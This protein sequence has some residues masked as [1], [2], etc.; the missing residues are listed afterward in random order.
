MSTRSLL[1]FSG[2]LLSVACPVWAQEQVALTEQP[3]REVRYAGTKTPNAAKL[4]GAES[5]ATVP[6]EERRARINSLQKRRNALKRYLSTV[7]SSSKDYQATEAAIYQLDVELKALTA[8]APAVPSSES[9]GLYSALPPLPQGNAAGA[10]AQSPPCPKVTSDV[11]GFDFNALTQNEICKVIQ[12][13]ATQKTKNGQTETQAIS[14]KSTSLV[15][16]PDSPD[17]GAI[18]TNLIG[19][20]TASGQSQG[21]GTPI[22][23]TLNAYT[24]LSGIKHFD[25]LNP[26]YYE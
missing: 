8:E 18:I 4:R 11:K 7:P 13:N 5:K 1:L 24:I 19:T 21:T 14:S 22:S 2:F 10:A 6:P 26:Y 16:K 17:L 23:V 9:G 20:S 25:P 12:A 3:S 15:D